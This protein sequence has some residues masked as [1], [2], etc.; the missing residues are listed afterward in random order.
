MSV[1]VALVAVRLAGAEVVLCTSIR[2]FWVIVLSELLISDASLAVSLITIDS[3]GPGWVVWSVSEG[4][5]ISADPVAGASVSNANDDN[6]GEGNI[7][8]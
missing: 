3:L 2:V 6:E 8:S 1:V 5:S 7:V 4:C